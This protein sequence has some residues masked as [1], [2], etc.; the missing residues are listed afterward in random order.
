M[1]TSGTYKGINYL[2]HKPTWGTEN[3]AKQP[4][5]IFL[6]GIGERGD[7]INDVRRLEVNGPLKHT[8]TDDIVEFKGVPSNFF[9]LAPQLPTHADYWTANYTFS[10]LEFAKANLDIDVN[11]IYL[12]G[13]SLGGGGVYTALQDVLIAPQIA[14]A[15]VIC[16]TCM[17]KNAGLIVANNIPVFIYHSV[18]DPRVPITCS[19]KA[20]DLIKNAGGNVRFY[21]MNGYGHNIW[22]LIL[23]PTKKAYK[24]SDGKMTVNGPTPYE[25]SLAFSKSNPQP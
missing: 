15:T 17:M 25:R 12:M 5:I 7:S 9:V 1:N 10:M 8:K 14:A 3:G 2:L 13:L 4:L 6:H 22:D 24:N 23:N 21:R 16:G 18:D 20:Y 19:E 11:R